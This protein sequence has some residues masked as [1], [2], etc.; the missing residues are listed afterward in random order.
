MDYEEGDSDDEEEIMRNWTEQ[1]IVAMEREK[2]ELTEC[3]DLAKGIF[4]NSK[5]ES[6]L[7][8][9]EKGFETTEEL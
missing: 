8:A 6:L 9:L 3:R 4:R 7:T 1:D 5:G 2:A